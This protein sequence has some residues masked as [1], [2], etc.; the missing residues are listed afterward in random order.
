MPNVEQINSNASITEKRLSGK[1]QIKSDWKITGACLAEAD[2]AV[3]EPIVQLSA[4]ERLRNER[5]AIDFL[6]RNQVRI[7]RPSRSSDY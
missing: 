6:H 3:K 7:Q 4:D 1:V 5:E 2:E